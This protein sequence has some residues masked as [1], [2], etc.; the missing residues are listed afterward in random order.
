MELR[1]KI[2][3]EYYDREAGQWL[4]GELK[5][6]G[7]KGGFD[8]FI[9]KSYIFLKNISKE[10]IRGKKVLDYG[11]GSGLNLEWLSIRAKEVVGIDLSKKSLEIAQKIV[12]QKKLNNVRLI[13]MDCE[14]LEFL[15]NSFDVIFD[16]GTLSSL[17]INKVLPEIKRVLKPGGF[18]IGIET[19]GHNPFTNL[20]RKINKIRKTR[21]EWAESHIIKNKDF[22]IIKEYFGD[23]KVYYFHLISW[24]AFPFLALPGGIYMLRFLEKIDSFLVSLFP[25]LK[26]YCFKIVFTANK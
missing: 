19:F 9:L 5:E 24:I 22:K 6:L 10:K 3:I 25:F 7:S 15:D 14:K 20:K 18:I 17:D 26:K 2:E 4:G 23:I 11:C 21:T 16:G 13:L 8:S 12:L 1:K